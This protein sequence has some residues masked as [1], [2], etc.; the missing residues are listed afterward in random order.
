VDDL[1]GHEQDRDQCYPRP[2]TVAQV[3]EVQRHQR[4]DD[5]ADGERG[6]V[7]GEWP[8]AVVGPQDVVDVMEEG[9]GD[10]AQEHPLTV[11]KS[12][13]QGGGGLAGNRGAVHC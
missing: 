2:G 9:K 5:E 3:A 1:Q 4:V 6:H 8:A 12:P 11:G 7:R 13:P 10:N